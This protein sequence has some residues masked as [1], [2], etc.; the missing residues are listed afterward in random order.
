VSPALFAEGGGAAT[1][2]QM[3]AV[4]HGPDGAGATA[5]GRTFKLK[6]LKSPE[7]QSMADAQ[8]IDLVTKGKG[9]MPAYGTRLSAAQIK[10]VVGYV[11]ELAKPKK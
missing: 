2:K 9:K 5:M 10:D 1:F 4:C 6:D 8:L 3:C 11:R 7:V